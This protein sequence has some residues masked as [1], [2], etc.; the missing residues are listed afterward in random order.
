MFIDDPFATIKNLSSGVV[1][2]DMPIPAATPPVANGEPGTAV[3]IPVT[4]SIENAL[5]LSLPLLAA[6][7]KFFTI[8]AVMRFEL[9]DPP[10]APFPPVVKGDPETG[11][12]TPSAAAENPEMVLGVRS[13]LVYT[14]V[15]CAITRK[16]Q[17]TIKRNR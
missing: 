5:T 1:V 10:P 14:N 2:N 17:N 9:K 13:L 16:V 8:A 3:R 7:K 6:Y 11:L 15:L 4:G 12:K